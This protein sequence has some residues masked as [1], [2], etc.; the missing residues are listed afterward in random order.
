MDLSYRQAERKDLH[1]IVQL[2]FQDELGAQRES[3]SGGLD[4]I[5]VSAF[6]KIQSDTNQEL[7]VAELEGEI[8]GTFQLSFLQY[9]TY[10]GCLRAQIEAVRVKSTHRGMGIGR[11][12]FDY[13]IVRSKQKGAHLL[14]LTTDKRRPEALKFYESIGFV[15]SHEGMK[16]HF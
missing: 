3:F 9:L 10:K 5:Y 6:E 12:M 7:Y 8:I 16:L 11:K 13:A 2:L 14:Q 15:A 4:E 1:D